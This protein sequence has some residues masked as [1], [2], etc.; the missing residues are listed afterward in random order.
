MNLRNLVEPVHVEPDLEEYIASVIFETRQERRVAVGASPRGSLAFLKMARAFAIMKGRDYIL[1]DDI[2]HFGHAVLSHRL[3]LQPE[4]WMSRQVGD[5][6]ITDVFRNVQV[7]VL[8]TK[9]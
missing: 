6:V 8:A 5:D 7:P 2:K 9:R 3:I 1:P 4:Y